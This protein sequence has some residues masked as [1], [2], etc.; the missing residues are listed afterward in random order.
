MHQGLRHKG[1]AGTAPTRRGAQAR[2][3][4]AWATV[5]LCLCIS[6]SGAG[7]FET[8]GDAFRRLFGADARVERRTEFLSE[9]AIDEIETVARA[10]IEHARVSYYVVSRNDSLLAR[11]YIDTH[12]VRT[13][14]ET[15]LFVFDP[16]GRV[17]T[18]EVLAFHE[19]EDYLPTR[20]WFERLAGVRDP[21]GVFPGQ[22][23]DA[24]SGATLSVRAAS[25]SLRRASAIDRNLHASTQPGTP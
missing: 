18:V 14:N 22:G 21:L 9:A 19:P 2:A 17:R 5:V 3:I 4:T 15:L 7:T 11:A 13:R 1:D 6:V 16:Q 20:R 8:R 23:V 12:Q 24:V 10:P 25:M